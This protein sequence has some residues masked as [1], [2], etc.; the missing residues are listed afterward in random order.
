M[1]IVKF[2]VINVV[3]VIVFVFNFCN[4]WKYV[5]VLIS[6]LNMFK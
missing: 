4:I 2:G 6:E 5:S 1:V 3:N